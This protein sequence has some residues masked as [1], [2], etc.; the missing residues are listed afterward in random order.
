M[1]LNYTNKRIVTTA[2]LFDACDPPLI[3]EVRTRPPREW[4]RLNNEFEDDGC[5][6]ADLARILISMA[7]LTVSDGENVYPIST[8]EQVEDLR[9]AIESEN[10]GYGNDFL[11]TIAWGFSTNHYTY[12]GNHLG[13]SLK[14][15][16][17]LN[18][19]GQEIIPVS[20]S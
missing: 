6:D 5:Q 16:A 3:F 19:S 7:F 18:G 12:L 10:L 4:A 20:E 13:N 9:L 11:C 1:K 14:P 15:L 17:Q 8:T 2:D